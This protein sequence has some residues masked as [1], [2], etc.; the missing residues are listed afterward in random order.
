M[1]GLFPRWMRRRRGMSSLLLSLDLSF[2]ENSGSTPPR[3]SIVRKVECKIYSSVFFCVKYR[4]DLLVL[5][6][7]TSKWHLIIKKRRQ[8]WYRYCHQTIKTFP[9]G[10]GLQTWSQNPRNLSVQ[11]YPDGTKPSI[12]PRLFDSWSIW[13]I[14]TITNIWVR[15]NI[16]KSKWH[17]FGW[18][19]YL[20]H[21]LHY[22]DFVQFTKSNKLI[23]KC[24]E[25]FTSLW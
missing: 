2:L 25:I 5:T 9:R 18:K 23:L 19:M 16:V 15:W 17:W 1:V 3:L 22:S 14:L 21:N 20:N 7:K 6:L 8:S 12:E 11:C 10:K 24:I 4:V 13:S